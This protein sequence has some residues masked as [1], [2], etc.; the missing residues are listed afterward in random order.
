MQIPKAQ[1]SGKAK[2]ILEVA[3]VV[4]GRRSQLVRTMESEVDGHEMYSG[5]SGLKRV[6]VSFNLCHPMLA[7]LQT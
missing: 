4:E 2:G 7:F 5:S 6:L 1:A 3:C